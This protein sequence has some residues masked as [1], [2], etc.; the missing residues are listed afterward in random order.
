[1][2]KGIPYLNANEVYLKMIKF[3]LSIRKFCMRVL[4]SWS[5]I[6]FNPAQLSLQLPLNTKLY[7]AHSVQF[8]LSDSSA[9]RQV[10]IKENL[11]DS[12]MHNWIKNV[13]IKT[14]D[15]N[16]LIDCIFQCVNN[17]IFAMLWL[18]RDKEVSLENMLNS[19]HIEDSSDVIKSCGIH[20]ARWHTLLATEKNGILNRSKKEATSLISVFLENSQKPQ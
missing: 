18:H 19:Q 20:Q 13:I 12:N 8:L 16:H 10:L 9:K 5:A 4:K 6:K 2:E 3:S 14:L 11:K 7:L 1:M 15:D 17:L